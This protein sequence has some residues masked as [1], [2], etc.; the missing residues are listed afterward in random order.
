[1]AKE[2]LYGIEYNYLDTFCGVEGRYLHSESFSTR[3]EAEAALKA[4]LEGFFKKDARPEIVEV[5]EPLTDWKRV[6]GL[7]KKEIK[8]LMPET[9]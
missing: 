7:N 6:R 4:N 2:K 3:N 1:M 9:V 5:D 8:Q